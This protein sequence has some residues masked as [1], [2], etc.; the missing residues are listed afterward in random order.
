MGDL[1]MTN[2]T[3]INFIFILSVFIL[4]TYGIAGANPIVVS[5]VG[6]D[7]VVRQDGEFE[8][9]IDRSHGGTIAKYFD[10][11]ID[12]NKTTNIAGSRY[13]GSF[14]HGLHFIMF[15]QGGGDLPVPERWTAQWETS[16]DMEIIYQSSTK[17]LVHIF[18]DFHGHLVLP[19]SYDMVYTIE[20]D[21]D[22]SGALIYIRS[23]I[24]FNN[25]YSNTMQIRQVFGLGNSSSWVEYSQNGSIAPWW[26]FRP[27]DD[28]IGAWINAANM[29]VDPVMILHRD[30]EIADYILTIAPPK[31][32]GYSLIGWVSNRWHNYTAG[33]VI[34]NKYL[35]RMDQRNVTDHTTVAPLAAA[36][37]ETDGGDFEG[38]ADVNVGNFLPLLLGDE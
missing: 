21:P 37:R 6:E 29:K 16:A 5:T 30:W 18:G 10:L 19:A 8:L 32:S 35:V 11:Q 15:K 1:K 13:E 33:H 7:I 22:T 23:R 25:N 36:Y 31:V 34:E 38:K 20:S 24:I 2:K 9:L 26:V 12:P 3:F 14:Y 27:G 28:Y 17:V 4:F